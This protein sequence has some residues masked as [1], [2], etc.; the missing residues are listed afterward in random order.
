MAIN[1]NL[2]YAK[3]FISP[4]VQ[5]C[6]EAYKKTWSAENRVHYSSRIA[7]IIDTGS[8]K[9][10][11]ITVKPSFV[12]DFSAKEKLFI[13][14]VL[15]LASIE[16]PEIKYI[17][18]DLQNLLKKRGYQNERYFYL[19]SL[20]DN[21]FSYEIDCLVDPGS[22]YRRIYYRKLS[23]NFGRKQLSLEEVFNEYFFTDFIELNRPRAKR[24]QR[25][26]GYRDHGS[27]GSEFSK[28]LKQQAGDWSIIEKE[29]QRRKQAD[30]FL[31][32]LSGLSGWE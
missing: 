1:P 5:H 14:E 3:S 2:C 26:K 22:T 17:L 9:D 4:I 7:S 20:T 32:F 30:D 23:C 11:I 15:R 10:I 16:Y 21:Q 6:T 31:S 27:L 19:N 25:H 24:K 29:E 28:T 8:S 12:K 18:D 13:Y